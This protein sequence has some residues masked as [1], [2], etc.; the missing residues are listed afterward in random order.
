MAE[1][2]QKS[3]KIETT[4]DSTND[5]FGIKVNMKLLRGKMDVIKIAQK[6]FKDIK[7]ITCSS[8]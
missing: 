8:I 2:V 4:L 6:C 1:V 5:R 3:F 7:L